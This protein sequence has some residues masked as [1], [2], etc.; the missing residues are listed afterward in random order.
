MENTDMEEV[1]PL[2]NDLAFFG[3]HARLKP[4]FRNYSITGDNSH[5]IM[6]RE[7]SFAYWEVSSH[8]NYRAALLHLTRV[9]VVCR[10]R[11]SVD[12]WGK[13]ARCIVLLR[14]LTSPRPS[15]APAGAQGDIDNLGHLLDKLGA[16]M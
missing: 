9:R 13:Y 7:L 1:L 15:K 11:L 6:N 14:R 4:Q 2:L 12:Y 5:L 3:D 8:H 16:I 10:E